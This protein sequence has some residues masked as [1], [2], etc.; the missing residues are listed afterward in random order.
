MDGIYVINLWYVFNL[1]WLYM[2]IYGAELQ[3]VAVKW[4]ADVFFLD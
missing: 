2:C 4:I 1:I 3:S